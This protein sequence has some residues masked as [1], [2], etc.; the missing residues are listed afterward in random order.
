MG[1]AAVQRA[2]ADG[3]IRFQLPSLPDYADKLKFFILVE[4]IDNPQVGEAA[5]EELEDRF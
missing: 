5:E 4:V 2:G 1:G 3:S